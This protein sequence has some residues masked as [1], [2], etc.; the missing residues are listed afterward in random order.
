M[1]IFHIVCFYLVPAFVGFRF[2]GIYGAVMMVGIGHAISRFLRKQPILPSSSIKEIRNTFYNSSFAVMGYIAK[3]DGHV[4]A[5][6]IAHAQHLFA[7]LRL[8]EE[9]KHSAMEHFRRGKSADFVLHDELNGFQA[10]CARPA[11]LTTMFL[12]MQVMMAFV[13]GGVDAQERAALEEIFNFFNRPISELERYIA[14]LRR[15]TEG[16]QQRS[17]SSGMTLKEAY[18]TL[19]VSESMTLAQIKRA[20]KKQMIQCHP[21]RL[22]GKGLPKEMIEVAVQKT[23]NLTAAFDYIKQHHKST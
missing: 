15:A 8:T 10:R 22:V 9:Q 5:S 18:E 16:A 14:Q 3:A 23:K 19:G 4:S 11:T 7:Q 20:Y 21:D 1:N 2:G 12:E 13:D 6:E 17:T